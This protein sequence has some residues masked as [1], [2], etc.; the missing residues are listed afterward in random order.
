MDAATWALGVAAA[1]SALFTG[2]AAYITMV[3]APARRK[4]PIA[5]ALASWR[6]MYPRAARVQATLSLLAIAASVAHAALKWRSVDGASFMTRRFALAGAALLGL[7]FVYTLAAIMPANRQL[8]DAAADARR[9]PQRSR[10]LLDRWEALH[11][12]RTVLAII[13]CGCYLC[14]MAT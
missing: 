1:A 8:M 12:V 11:A 9:G 14:G 5:P 13:A 6:A 7:V 2:A 4:L 10:A 3:D